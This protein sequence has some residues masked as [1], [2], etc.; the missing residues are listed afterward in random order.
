MYAKSI[1]Q[2]ACRQ[3]MHSITCMCCNLQNLRHF[4]KVQI[5]YCAS[6]HRLCEYTVPHQALIHSIKCL[7]EV[8]DPMK[9]S[10]VRI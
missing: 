9:Y 4:L 3:E 8:V 1:D 2:P 5:L 10:L 6:I 7:H